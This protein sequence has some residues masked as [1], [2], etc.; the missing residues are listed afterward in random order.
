MV[1]EDLDHIANLHLS[2]L[3]SSK[4]GELPHGPGGAA[5]TRLLLLLLLC[6]TPCLHGAESHVAKDLHFAAVHIRIRSVPLLYNRTQ[7][8]PG[9]GQI[10][11]SNTA[12]PGRP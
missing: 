6:P 12:H 10:Q 7:P 2:P 4:P 3:Q 8:P 9:W 5:P 11:Y 1:V